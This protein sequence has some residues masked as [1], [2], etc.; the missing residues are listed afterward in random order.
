M[1]EAQ[2]PFVGEAA[3]LAFAA[4]QVDGSGLD[5]AAILSVFAD[6]RHAGRLWWLVSLYPAMTIMGQRHDH[7]EAH[8]VTWGLLAEQSPAPRPKAWRC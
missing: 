3:L 8:T 4:H 1:A 2:R 5:V 6:R 7:D